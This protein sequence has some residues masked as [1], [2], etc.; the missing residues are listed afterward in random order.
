MLKKCKSLFYNFLYWIIIY[1]YVSLEHIVNVCCDL[2]TI[3]FKIYKD[4]NFIFS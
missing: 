2:I 3:V 1:K 4:K